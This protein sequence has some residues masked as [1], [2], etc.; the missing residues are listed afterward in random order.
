MPIPF[1]INGL[2]RIGRALVRVASARPELEL[3]AAND[4]AAPEQLARL[5]RHDTVHGRFP[6]EVGYDSG[7]LADGGPGRDSAMEL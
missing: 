6:G 2:G 1:A 3:V 5:L 7:A 4:S